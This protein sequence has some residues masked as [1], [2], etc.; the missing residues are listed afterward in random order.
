MLKKIQIKGLFDK[1]DYDIELKEG[2][3]TILT[4]PNGYGKTTILGIIYA[5]AV[6]DQSFFSQIPFVEIA[7]I[8]DETE[9]IRIEKKN[10]RP[11]FQLGNDRPQEEGIDPEKIFRLLTKKNVTA[12]EISRSLQNLKISQEGRDDSSLEIMKFAHNIGKVIDILDQSNSGNQETLGKFHDEQVPTSVIPHFVDCY[13]IREQRLIRDFLDKNIPENFRNMIEEYSKELSN[14]IKSILGKAS[15][16]GQELDSSFPERLFDEIGSITEEEFDRRYDAIKKKQ[17]ALGL[18]GLS[19]TQEERHTSFKPENAKALLVYLN[20]TE[21]KL[22]VFDDILQ[23]LDLFSSI[24]NRRQFVSKQIEISPEFGFRFKTEDDKEL[25]LAALSSGEQ[26]EVVLL[27]ELLFRVAPDTLVLID[28]PE[29]SLHVAWQKEFIDDLLRIIDLQKI[30][31][32]VATHSP[33]IV[34]GRWDLVV[35][36]WDLATTSGGN[37]E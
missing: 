22:A 27:Y 37:P 10:G 25:P 36:L 1:F 14:N 4:G 5:I 30:T 20:D 7:L 15:K 16:I 31:V 12:R 19:T 21:K 34:K 9:T 2:G 3:L 17:N 23:R 33:Q 26:Q 28:E 32:L 8:Q 13:F 24:L 18:Y 6:K 29:I 35:D 11:D